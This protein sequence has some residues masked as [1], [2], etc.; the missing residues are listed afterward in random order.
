MQALAIHWQPELEYSDSDADTD[1]ESDLKDTM[2]LNANSDATGST[3][4]GP[5]L[6]QQPDLQPAAAAT[7]AT[8][9]VT[10][11][12]ASTEAAS[13]VLVP[14]LDSSM[15]QE[16]DSTRRQAVS[17]TGTCITNILHQAHFCVASEQCIMLEELIDA[18][19][20][21]CDSK[22][23]A[24]APL[25]HQQALFMSSVQLTLSLC[26][27]LL[28]DVHSVG[29]VAVNTA[30]AMLPQQGTNTGITANAS[31]QTEAVKYDAMLGT[32]TQVLLQSSK[33]LCTCRE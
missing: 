12:A 4:A 16:R 2:S 21:L 18:L 22:V 27:L 9:A 13:T 23:H 7:A 10:T 33:M 26:I 24:N 17:D 11:A 28:F 31:S 15:Q 19:C 29:A 6:R 20:C 5:S 25:S 3:P 1:M 8:A 32:T 14:I 30:D